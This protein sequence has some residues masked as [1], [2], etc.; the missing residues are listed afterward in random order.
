MI[1]PSH[2]VTVLSPDRGGDFFGGWAGL[3]FCGD[4]GGVSAVEVGIEGVC[5][6]GCS[7]HG[8]SHAGSPSL[9]W[10]LFAYGS[11]CGN[12]VV[13]L[14]HVSPTLSLGYRPHDL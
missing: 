2:R 12:V 6:D 8:A 9:V 13:R 4:A 7:T 14:R 1:G 10:R 11:G 3:G 5:L